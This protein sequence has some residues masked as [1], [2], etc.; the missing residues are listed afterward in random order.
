MPGKT[1]G[2]ER[3]PA[4]PVPNAWTL[5]SALRRSYRPV[6]AISRGQRDHLRRGTTYR[7]SAPVLTPRSAS[8]FECSPHGSHD[9]VERALDPLGSQAGFVRLGLLRRA[10]HRNV[11]RDPRP[12]AV[13]RG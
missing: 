3:S 4:P 9:R 6:V 7:V 2:A 8:V 1:P 12:V 11:D 5:T 10:L 13:L